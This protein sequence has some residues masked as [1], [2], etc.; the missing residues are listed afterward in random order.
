MDYVV[1]FSANELEKLIEIVQP[2]VLA[3]GSNYA[4]TEVFG[5]E[6]VEAMGGRVVL[7]PVTE[8]TSSTRIIN[9]IKSSSPDK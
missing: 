4:S 8:N 9:T 7:I 1:V 2:D 3:K 5:H 6:R